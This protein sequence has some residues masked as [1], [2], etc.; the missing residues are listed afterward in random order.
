MAVGSSDLMNILEPEKLQINGIASGRNLDRKQK[1]NKK[2]KSVPNMTPN[3]N[4]F[5][6]TLIQ[7][8]GFSL[9]VV[10]KNEKNE[11]IRVMA[12]DGTQNLVKIKKQT[13]NQW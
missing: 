13:K 8:N 9:A 3:D 11:L 4:S 10:N 2:K 1:T 6:T 5:A 12:A 7:P